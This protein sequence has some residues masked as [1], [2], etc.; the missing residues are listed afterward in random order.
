MKQVNKLTCK[1]N[2]PV[3]LDLVMLATKMA[4]VSKIR[5]IGAITLSK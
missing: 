4:D 1:R 5:E 2:F 3:P